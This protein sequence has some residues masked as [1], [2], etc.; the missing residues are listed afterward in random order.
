MEQNKTLIASAAAVLVLSALIF[1]VSKQSN[2]I[3][4]LKFQLC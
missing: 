3:D 4:Q 2:D 1:K